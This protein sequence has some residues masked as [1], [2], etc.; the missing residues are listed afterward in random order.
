MTSEETAIAI[1]NYVERCLE[2]IHDDVLSKHTDITEHELQSLFLR[3]RSVIIQEIADTILTKQISTRQLTKM[4]ALDL[5]TA[6]AKTRPYAHK[7]E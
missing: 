7:G 3:K 2:K 5:L 4:A 1:I 6:I